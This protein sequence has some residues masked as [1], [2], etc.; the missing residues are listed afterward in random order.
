KKDNDGD[1]DDE[2]EDDDHISDIQDT[3]DEDAKTKFDENEIYKCKIQVHKD[4]DVEMGEAETVKR[5]N[6][7][8]DEMP[9]AAKADV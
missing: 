8:N 9:D 7:E 6:K 2:D 3:K 4:V 5:E 1:V